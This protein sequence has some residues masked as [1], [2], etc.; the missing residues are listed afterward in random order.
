MDDSG[1]DARNSLE[2]AMAMR[3]HRIPCE[4]HIFQHGRHGVGL[5]EGCDNVW[6]WT[7]LL[8]EWL[9]LNGY[10]AE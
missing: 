3:A 7:N 5:G 10:A 6:Q 8:G 2:L 9:K 1:V 4:L